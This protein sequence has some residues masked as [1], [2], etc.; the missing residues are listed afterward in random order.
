MD[1]TVLKKVDGRIN[2][3]DGKLLKKIKVTA[4]ARVST[5]MEE[6]LN[7]FNSQ[8]KYYTEKI[9]ENPEWTYVEL[10]A[11]EGISGTQDFKRT[12]FL[13]M[14]NDALEGK[15]DLILT[16]SISRFARNTLDTL[17][18]V[19]L[20][21]EHNVGV[22]F[23][24]E[25]INT[26]DMTGELLLT[27]L[28]SV[29]QQ[30]SETISNHVKLGQKMKTQRGELI[31]FNNCLGYRYDSKTN[32][33]TIV[34]EEADIVRMIFNWYLEGY[35]AGI[36]SQ[37][38]SNM[39][40]KTFRGNN[41]WH[42][43]V[44]YGILHNEKYV[45]DAMIG[46]TF[47]LDPISHKRMKNF[48]EA[49]KFYIKDHH[50][51]IISREA[52]DK[53]QKLI[54]SRKGAR[55]YGRLVS[56]GKK[57]VFSSRIRCGYCGYTYG[58][59]NIIRNVNVKD[60]SWSCI[61]N[62]CNGRHACLDS[63]TIKEDVIK[64]AFVDSFKLLVRETKVDSKNLLDN[65]KNAMRDNSPIEKIKELNVKKNN[66]KSRKNKLVDCMIDGTISK[67]IY[68][69][70]LND[71]ESKIDKVEKEIES[72]TII[73]EDDDK[74]ENGIYK[75]SQLIQSN[76]NKILNDFDEDV[77]TALVD[78]IV[79]GGYDETGKKDQFMIRFICKTNFKST[80]FRTKEIEHIVE[81]NHIPSDKYLSLLDFES[82]QHFFY[83]DTEGE[84]RTKKLVKYVRVR[85]EVEV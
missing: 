68:Q 70:K 63:K 11:D 82:D 53:V 15:I 34:E 19:R 47:T 50:K 9:N 58:R 55:A 31:G 7:S 74:I 65:I 44:I 2:R 3:K 85:V 5:D 28:S 81:T 37:K 78:Y 42:D 62:V 56:A 72:Y 26:L 46:K 23:E 14:I 22:L 77:F 69:Q 57:G 13:K 17:K 29:A 67:E 32:E 21:R 10:Y 39:K 16:K 60:R 1:I 54:E 45:G 12:Q 20:L 75:I 66:L 6:Q 84:K 24:E 48:G 8:K 27:I 40:I 49:D 79:I 43:T 35:G 52:F 64:K 30:E 18:Y 25:N 51:P 80:I 71:L 59:K 73:K 38:L 83:F 61:Q 36:I 4:Y 41:K 33:M 76:S